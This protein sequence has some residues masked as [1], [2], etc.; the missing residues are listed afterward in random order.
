MNLRP[1]KELEEASKSSADSIRF[2]LDKDYDFFE[3]DCMIRLSDYV[4]SI[5]DAEGGSLVYLKN[6]LHV[7]VLEDTDDI[8]AQIYYLN[9]SIWEK[10]KEWVNIKI[11]KFKQKGTVSKN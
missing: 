6:G 7:S 9:R 3:V 5:D 1:P 10:L 2:E 4:M 11:N 8:V